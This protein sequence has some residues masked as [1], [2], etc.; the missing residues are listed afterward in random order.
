MDGFERRTEEKKKRVLRA[1]FDLMNSD[2]GI[3]NLTIDDVAK[4][5]NVGKT[6][7]FKY[8][9]SKENLIHEVFIRSMEEMGNNAKK[10]M[11]KNAPFEETLIAMSQVKIE[12]LDKINKQFYL[13]LMKYYTKKEDSGF[14]RMMEEYTKQSFGIMLDLFHRGRK[15]GKVDL[16]YS[17][18]FLMLYFQAII[19]GISNPQIYE[20]IMP[21]TAEWTEM[22][23]KGIAPK[24]NPIDGSQF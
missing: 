5:A 21:Y 3:E 10:V 13:D 6:S 18:E 19:E 14:T 16:K 15:E 24:N 9:G 23:V 11:A 20:K 8:F 2:T 12:Y 22:L 4:K 7:I 17:D 1:A